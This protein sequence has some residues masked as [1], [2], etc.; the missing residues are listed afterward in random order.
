MKDSEDGETAK[1]TK[2]KPSRSRSR[3]KPADQAPDTAKDQQPLPAQEVQTSTAKDD[4]AQPE[5]PA[6]SKRARGGRSGSKD[7][8]D[9]RKVVVGMGD[10]MP[11][12]IAL[13]FDER[14]AS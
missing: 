2:P 4:D 10:H 11:S 8:R 12:F 13:S 14:R 1:E 5:K 3:S 6:S 9:D 7:R